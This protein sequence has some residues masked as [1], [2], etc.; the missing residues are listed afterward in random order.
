MIMSSHCIDAIM[1][2]MDQ[3]CNMFRES[4][5]NN[6]NRFTEEKLLN[7][8]AYRDFFEVL[9]YLVSGLRYILKQILDNVSGRENT[10]GLP[11]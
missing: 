6:L 10:Y 1:A 4:L 3:H 8:T 11:F 5:N 2:N 7:L 9:Y